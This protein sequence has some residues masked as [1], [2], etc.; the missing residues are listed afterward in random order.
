M[1]RVGKRTL[2]RL[3]ILRR[4]QGLWAPPSGSGGT[5]SFSIA[6]ESLHHVSIR[7]FLIFDDTF[8]VDVADPLW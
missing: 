1:P 3:C 7:P 4:H 2:P 8:G 6:V 5:E